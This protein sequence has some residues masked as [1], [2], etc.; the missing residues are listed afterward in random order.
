MDKPGASA[1]QRTPDHAVEQTR[2]FGRL[3]DRWNAGVAWRKRLAPGSP[4]RLRGLGTRVLLTGADQCVASL[5][6]FAV[7]VA[8]ARVAGIAALGAYSLAYVI[9]LAFAAVH[10]A[11][12][13]EPMAIENDVRGERANHNV[14]I[15]FAGEM[16]L[17]AACACVVACVG[18]VLLVIGQ[19][20]Y[21]VA[22]VA[23]SPWLP[24]LLVQDYWRWVAFMKA[25]PAKALA[26]DVLFDVIQ[27]IAFVILFFS[28][29]RSSVLAIGAWGLGACAGTAF[30]LVQHAVFPSMRG[31]IR[32]MRERW[33]TS[34]GLLGGS[35]TNWGA[36][37]SYVVLTGVLLGPVG[38]GGL[39]AALSLVSG[40]TQVL[41]QAGGSIGLPEA[42][43]ALHERGWKGLLGVERAI[44]LAGIASIGLVGM[45]VLAFGGRLLVL[46]YGSGFGCFGVTADVLAL[47][48][49]VG[50]TSLGA[51][52][53]LKATRLTGMLFGSS[54]FAL[55]VSIVS[56]VVMVPPFG[57]EGAAVASVLR[58]AAGSS[59][60]L[61]F[62]GRRA[63]KVAESG[64]VHRRNAVDQ[65][66][67]RTA[68]AVAPIPDGPRRR[69]RTGRSGGGAEGDSAD[70][71]V[72][73]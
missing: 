69:E 1:R 18:V 50:T 72:I 25:A 15:G 65:A 6:N 32:R 53:G 14:Q 62:H 34:R 70:T 11:L 60:Q 10:R 47:S 68:H 66:E 39:R 8:I 61:I 54:L 28:G 67:G 12:V 37:Q 35:V 45:V 48:M 73:W 63:R 21:G 64:G 41:I 20:A 26:N 44:T 22:F 42:S 17:G 43:R 59:T 49:L 71:I 46:F 55:A 29:V 33:P 5:S 7:G 9:W 51:I 2:A 13:A 38:L 56:V 36:Q 23:L 57:V 52:L 58:S 31:G 4:G 24:F 27:G 19:H 30:G 40:P 16:A 3:S